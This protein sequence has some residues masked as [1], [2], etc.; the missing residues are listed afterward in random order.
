MFPGTGLFAQDFMG[1]PYE[2]DSRE[3]PAAVPMGT[4]LSRALHPGD[5]DW[6]SLRPASA[7]ILVAA[8]SGNTDT[9]ISLYLGNEMIA[10]N[11]D[12]GDEVSSLLEYPVQGGVD[13]LICVN[14]Y[15]ADEAGP[16]H[17]MASLEPIYDA[18]PNDVA[19][20][21]MI[22]TLGNPIM[23][24]FLDAD[25][26]NWYRVVATQPGTLVLYTE[27]TMDTIIHLYDAR[28]NLI[29]E[30]DDGGHRE[31]ARISIRVGT[32]TM[33][34]KVSAY[35]GQLG[36]YTLR[37]LFFE[38]APADRFEDDGN[39]TLAKDIT[40]G[41]AQS[42]T[43]TDSFDEDWARLRID[44]QGTYDITAEAQDSDLLD[45]LLELYDSNDR[46]IATN[47]DWKGGLDARIRLELNPGTYYIRVRTVTADPIRNSSYI[48]RV[49]R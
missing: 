32:G 36:R 26:V 37:G 7:G 18:N 28:N 12:N 22:L 30:D 8:T 21:A 9:V 29:A 2:P 17:F 35:N 47:D 20:E 49:T 46:L 24:Y 45:T 3:R 25:D 48:L 19:S 43:F 16:Y 41:M 38:P 10:Q 33:F 31:N 4:W 5:E 15:A 23:G 39:K 13:Y 6:F 40:A 27:G 42:R 34:A 44:R 14:S 11:D 1:D